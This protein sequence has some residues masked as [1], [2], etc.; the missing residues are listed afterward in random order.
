MGF[1]LLFHCNKG[2]TNARLRYVRSTLPVVLN[3]YGCYRDAGVVPA[4]MSIGLVLGIET[5]KQNKREG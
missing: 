4:I 1:L 2:C 5:A 3:I